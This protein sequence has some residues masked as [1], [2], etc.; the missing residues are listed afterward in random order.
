[1]SNETNAAEPSG[2][3]AGSP[4]LSVWYCLDLSTPT[5]TRLEGDYQ[6]ELWIKL[7]MLAALPVGSSVYLPTP[8]Q[9]ERSVFELRGR[10]TGWM[11]VG[12]VVVCEMDTPGSHFNGESVSDLL[13]IGYIEP[14]SGCPDEVGAA[15][16][17][18][19]R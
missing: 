19:W 4:C 16:R 12:E 3:S 13:A 14:E 17:N 9:W 2:A 11:A 18:L 6:G 10:I 5:D 8:R 7:P 1:M 15:Y